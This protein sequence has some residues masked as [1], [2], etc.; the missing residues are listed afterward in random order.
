VD[1]T[2]IVLWQLFAVTHSNKQQYA[3][4][5]QWRKSVQASGWKRQLHILHGDL[6]ATLLMEHLF[7]FLPTF[8]F[9]AAAGSIENLM[10]PLVS[11]YV[12]AN[13]CPVVLPSLMHVTLDYKYTL[14]KDY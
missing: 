3:G 7:L 8:T 14:F 4:L 13:Q 11:R 6:A 10:I 2:H 1:S 12:V 9:M 5:L